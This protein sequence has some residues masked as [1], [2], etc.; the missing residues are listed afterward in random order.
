[1]NKPTF[2]NRFVLDTLQRN[3]MHLAGITRKTNIKLRFLKE[4][5]GKK[6]EIQIMGRGRKKPFFQ[7]QTSLKKTKFA[8][9]LVVHAITCFGVFCKLSSSRLYKL[10]S[11]R[12]NHIP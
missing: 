7:S 11:S 5:T 9:F 6:P 3:I 10:G 4:G 8:F 2:V 12:P 1:M